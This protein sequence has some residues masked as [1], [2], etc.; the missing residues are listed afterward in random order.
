M[1]KEQE[2]AVFHTSISDLPADT[3]V[4]GPFYMGYVQGVLSVIKQLRSGNW[5]PKH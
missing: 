4:L 5:E 3:N 2:E 1:T